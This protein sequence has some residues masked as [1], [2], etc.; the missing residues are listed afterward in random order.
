MSSR[1]VSL[2]DL[3]ITKPRGEDKRY[4]GIVTNIETISGSG[5]VFVEWSNDR[6]P[7]YNTIYGYS[8]IN[9][10]NCFDEFTI[11]KAK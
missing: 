4:A 2:G 8:A 1:Y 11:V 3:I 10:H 6:P 7:S 5:C 9:I